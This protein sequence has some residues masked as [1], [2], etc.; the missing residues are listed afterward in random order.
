MCKF[1][2]LLDIFE[3]T[4]TKVILLVQITAFNLCESLIYFECCDS[5][6]KIKISSRNCFRREY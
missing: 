6:Q 4:R 5:T 3:R 2:H 1:E